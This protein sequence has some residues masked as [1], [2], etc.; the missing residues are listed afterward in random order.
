MKW[1]R[2][3]IG[4][5][6]LVVLLLGLLVFAPRQANLQQGSTY[7][8][9]PSGYGAWYAYMQDKG[10]AI[11]RWERLVDDFPERENPS[12]DP[13]ALSTLVQIFGTSTNPYIFNED[14]VQQGNVLVL[15]GVT[16]PVTEAP[17]NCLL[18]SAV[19]AVQVETSRRHLVGQPFTYQAVEEAQPKA[20]LADEHGA[21]VWQ[22]TLG[23]GRVILVVTP[24]LGAN[25]YQDA[26][27]NFEFLAQLV[28][29]AGH[30]IW[31]DEY[32]HGYEDEQAIAADNPDGLLT[33]LAKTP[34]ALLS[35]Q[36][37]V[38]L[39]ALIWGQRRL[40]TAKSLLAAAADNNLAYIQALAAVLQKAG[41][42]GFVLETVGKA[43]QLRVQ[44]SLGLGTDLLEPD[45]VLAAWTQTG[46]P[47]AELK[48][49]LHPP[50]RDRLTE[51]ELLIWIGQ[52]QTVHRHLPD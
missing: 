48:A 33:Y 23:R 24:H 49:V 35:L 27:G 45:Q 22:E 18:D 29:E 43:E 10:V 41:C 32:L 5:G 42:S 14:W 51:S 19:G 44:R 1:Q 20:L 26:A 13:P 2:G 30:P 8:R 39:L 6:L 7:S 16:A 12:S 34:L 52:V 38:L 36:A 28:T 50:R 9:S 47:A 17:F 40:G 37:I 3:W 25:A 31:I 21:V 46:R 4:V 15:V 11:D